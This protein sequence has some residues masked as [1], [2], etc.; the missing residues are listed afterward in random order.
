MAT[1]YLYVNGVDFMHMIEEKGL[2]FSYNDID[3]PDSGRTLDAVMHR[4]KV[5]TKCKIE[6]KFWPLTLKEVST[7]LR[8]LEPQYVSVST[9][10]DPRAGGNAQ[11]TMYNSTRLAV[12][13]TFDEKEQK[14]VW[15]DISCTLIE[16]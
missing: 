13:F 9:N 11:Y 8:A 2:K 5:A 15:D 10:V 1:P 3:A 14:S 7:V 12:A 4:G 6:I 16:V